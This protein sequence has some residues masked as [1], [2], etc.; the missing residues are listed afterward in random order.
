MNS[1]DRT[2]LAALARLEGSPCL[3][4][5][6]PVTG[7][8]SA[9]KQ[10]PVRLANLIREAVGEMAEL[11]LDDEVAQQVIEPIEAMAAAE[12]FWSIPAGGLAFF[13][14]PGFLRSVHVDFDFPERV[15]LGERFSIRPLLPL[16]TR[17]ERF[18]ALAVSLKR[19][20]LLEG[21][22]E[23]FRELAL[24]GLPVSFD[25]EMGYEEYDTNVYTHTGSPSALGRRSA[26][27]H[28]HGDGDEENLKDDVFHFLRRVVEALE[29]GL[30]E[31][32]APFVL[33]AVEPYHPLFARANRRL[34]IAGEGI[35]GNPDFLSNR[36]LDQQARQ[37]VRQEALHRLD[38][39]LVR[40]VELRASRRGV[41]D[42]EEIVRAADQ[43]ALE[44][45]FLS[46]E[47]ERW[48]SY[49]PDLGRVTV[50]ETRE[51]G[52]VELLEMAA[53][54]TLTNGGEVYTLPLGAMPEGRIALAIRRYAAAA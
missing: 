15:V 52:D 44:T 5:F 33:A 28:G 35:V 39:E 38:A 51:R 36:E 9:G 23:D 11:D 47:A 14:A 41:E 46:R 49:E 12:G 31:A 21:G 37:I 2:Q 17:P 34:R 13:S 4:L 18:Y 32:S 16:L 1:L 24:P 30:P 54:R 8:G 43:G 19:V 7:G 6:M 20:R 10:D 53:V 29:R 40:W 26:L 22:R 42:F 3:S 48:G 27:F 50:H 25:A 45:L